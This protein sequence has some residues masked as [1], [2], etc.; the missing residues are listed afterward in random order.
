[1]SAGPFASPLKAGLLAALA[2]VYGDVLRRQGR[3]TTPFVRWSKVT[4]R[5]HEF[6][7]VGGIE[8][9]EALLNGRG[10][11]R[12]RADSPLFAP[13][14]KMHATATLNPYEREILYGYPYAIG[15]RDG[16]TVR[17]PLLTLAVRIE[18]HRD[19]F[20]VHAADDVAHFNA[21]PFKAEGDLDV[22]E[23][24]VGRVIGATPAVPLDAAGLESLAEALLREF[25]YVQRRDAA[26]DGRLVAPPEEPRGAAD[27]GLWLVD[28]AALFIAPKTSYFLS[29]DLARIGAAEGTAQTSVLAPLLGGPG[30]EAQVDLDDARVDSAHVFF[31]FP[32]N[33]SQRRAALLVD[34][35]TT[36]VIRVEGPPGTGKSL[37]IANLACHL[38]ATGKTVLISSQKDKALDVVDGKLRELGMAELPMTLL[39]RDRESKKDLLRRLERIKKE[40]SHL[41]VGPA[42]ETIATRFGAEADATVVDARE[43]SQAIACEEALERA[44]RAVGES[45]GFS[46]LA[47]QARFWHTRWK[48]SRVASRTTD[49]LAEAA[50]SRRKRLLDLAVEALQLGRELAVSTAS[51][52]ERAGLR[53]LAAVL[54]RDQTRF[55]NFSLFDRL[56][57]NPDRAAMLLKLLPVWIMTPDDVARLF[58]CAPGLFD[59]VI[60]DEA[61]QVDLPSI[62]PVAYRGKKLVIF[63]DSKQM[64]PR[65]FA[66]M[67]Q[68]VT[69]QAWQ[70]HG[71]E[72]L[73]SERWLHPSEQSLLTLATVRAEEEALLDEHFRSLPPIIQFSN[74][75]WYDARL[76]V[77]TDVRHKRF[78]R[79]DQPIMQLHHVPEG[80]ITNGSQEN[81]A[82]AQALVALLRRL[83]VDPDY[84]GAS[85][86]VM[87]LFEEQVALVQD[88]V[89]EQ[90][91]PE[92]WEDHE[93]VV[94]NPDGFQGDERDVILYSLSYDASVMPQAAIS[95]RM[96]DQAHVQ[97]MLNV[98]FTRA[99]DEIHI[100]HSATVEAFT[101]AEGRPG[102][103]TD[104]LRHSAQVQA[105][106]R[107]ALA[108]SRL[109]EV[110]SQFEA[111]VAAALRARGLRVL[112]QYPA[113][114]FNV[115]LVVEREAEGV[116]VAVEC[117][118]ERY[119]L[120]EHGLLKT[121]DI[122]RQAILERANWRV[123]RIPYRKWL[124]DPAAAVG[125]VV[126][127]LDDVTPAADRGDGGG[128][129][130]VDRGSAPRAAITGPELPVTP[131]SRPRTGG[132]EREWVSR[133]EAALLEALK[134][135]L[136]AEEDVFLR[137]RDLLGSRRLT[138]KLRRALQLATSD[139]ARR[140]LIAIEDQEYFVLPA[141]RDA[142]PEP[143]VATA[144]NP[145]ANRATPEPQPNNRMPARVASR[146][147]ARFAVRSP[148]TSV[149]P[150]SS[151]RVV[152]TF[153]KYRNFSLAELLHVDR[154]Y[155]DWLAYTGQPVPAHVRAAARLILEGRD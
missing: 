129:A 130:S 63:G 155:V 108:G 97:G 73:D 7:W 148:F 15:R 85:L 114:G 89:A 88:L 102:A 52:E 53:E 28:Q 126:A 115:D 143:R 140:K 136:S 153:G 30:A 38:A 59:V 116:R 66:F 81:E 106:P 25:R 113:C 11:L 120:D 98:A 146:R 121:E 67:S 141:G 55:K 12:I 144:S 117:D 60:V 82:E 122:E 32:S 87:C 19:G 77:M 107:A 9:R 22:H 151:A 132:R 78:G 96:S 104:W 112:H 154:N 26:L 35:P 123:V 86:G 57:G 131:A 44:H 50:S 119:H 45:G 149:E 139:L 75:R 124:A 17:G 90:I 92:E 125:R 36:R 101:F 23:Q 138:Q 105:T 14:Q 84:N 40:R 109:G 43:Y 133:E 20:L 103:L 29:S 31:P 71:M 69:R 13:V 142:T 34:D 79:P 24:K 134:E 70:Q 6:A 76:R 110:D 8:T 21:L 127:A 62:T 58:P 150:A 64:Q 49:A 100:F 93:L 83:V 118:G 1:M 16:E 80:V 54:K 51:R 39:R 95:A 65:R 48:V 94:I 147:R 2:R 61:S 3:T 145:P 4:G 91:A 42:F 33:R 111:D 72:L 152:L 18:V 27:Q 137:V 56:K 10:P 47:R 135:G 37:T 74:E 41:E 99:R 68:D 46:R 5:A 128:E